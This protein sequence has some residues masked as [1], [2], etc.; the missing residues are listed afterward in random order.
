MSCISITTNLEIA[1]EIKGYPIYAVVKGGDIYN[2]RTGRK[3]KKTVVGYSKGVWFGKDFLTKS[4]LE[5]LLI[6]PVNVNCPF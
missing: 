5:I 3:I 4:K 6:K 2:K 1:Y